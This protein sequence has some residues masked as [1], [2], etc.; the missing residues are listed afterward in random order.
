VFVIDASVAV[1][2]VADEPGSDA[3]MAYVTAS[4]TLIAPDW[5]LVE[6]ASALW[7]KVQAGAIDRN[8]AEA[9]LAAVPEFFQHLF[10]T[11]DLLQRGYALALDLDHAVYDCLYLALA[12]AEEAVLITADKKFVTTI[13]RRGLGQHVR[14]LDGAAP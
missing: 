11:L 6:A 14:L 7:N 8:G 12:M 5:V 4:Q 13:Q 9:G 10:G 2:F 3:A 1:K